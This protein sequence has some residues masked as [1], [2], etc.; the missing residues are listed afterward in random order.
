[1]KSR[2][3]SYMLTAAA[4]L[5]SLV[6]GLG[7][8]VSAE[9]GLVGPNP[10][11]VVGGPDP[12]NPGGANPNPSAVPGGP[13]PSDPGDHD[14]GVATV[15]PGNPVPSAVA[16]TA[17]QVPVEEEPVV[18]DGNDN[19]PLS[20]QPE[21]PNGK[22]EGLINPNKTTTDQSAVVEDQAQG[23]TGGT[24]QSGSSGTSDTVSSQADGSNSGQTGASSSD[25]TGD[26]SSSVNTLP[27][28]GAGSGRSINY[29][30]MGV[31]GVLSLILLGGAFALTRRTYQ[32]S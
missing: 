8:S 26:D 29:S 7:T 12:S 11:A 27:E 21:G 24:T 22:A 30:A 15:I 19:I 3:V 25:T 23:D 10:S 31:L 14:G 18:D 1:M 17:T 13:D 9:T 2:T 28:A 16:P 5:L 4:L 20:Q 32:T 6:F